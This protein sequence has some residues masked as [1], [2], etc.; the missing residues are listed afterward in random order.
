VDKSCDEIACLAVEDIF[1]LF[2]RDLAVFQC[3]SIKIV[4]FFFLFREILL[5]LLISVM[6]LISFFILLILILGTV[7]P[8]LILV[9]VMLVVDRR[10]TF[11]YQLIILGAGLRTTDCDSVGRLGLVRRV[12]FLLR[13]KPNWCAPNLLQ[14]ICSRL[15]LLF[16]MYRIA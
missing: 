2:V 4:P 8:I 16:S 9:L 3:N 1:L 5:L 14:T 13:V 11:L 6:V 15:R 12:Y 7:L 10:V